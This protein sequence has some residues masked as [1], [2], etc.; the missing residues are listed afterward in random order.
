MPTKENTPTQ[1][2]IL[3]NW[4][5][6]TTSSHIPYIINKL[7]FQA[8]WHI[9]C[10][11]EVVGGKLTSMVFL[12]LFQFLVQ[13]FLIEKKIWGQGEGEGNQQ[14]WNMDWWYDDCLKSNETN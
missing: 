10:M 4:I 9:Y 12:Q 8:T 6:T 7:R 11:A 13:V 2:E 1:Q 14:T 5:H 3:W